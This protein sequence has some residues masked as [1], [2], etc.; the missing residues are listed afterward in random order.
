M[1]KNLIKI[2]R[3][4]DF[5]D[6]IR[7]ETE[8]YMCIS[9]KYSLERVVK[10]QLEGVEF[11][12]TQIANICESLDNLQKLLE[13]GFKIRIDETEKGYKLIVRKATCSTSF[14]A[15]K[16]QGVANVLYQAEDWAEEMLKE[17]D[18]GHNI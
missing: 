3:D 6:A 17:L 12:E 13:E 16:E 2:Q 14:S 1:T 11:D 8:R 10:R 15:T 4:G 9:F 18:Q 7:S 5:K